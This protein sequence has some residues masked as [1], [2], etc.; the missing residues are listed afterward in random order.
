MP[1]VELTAP[2]LRPGSLRAVAFSGREAVSELYAYD[3]L[4][5]SPWVGLALPQNLELELLGS[6]AHLSFQT[7]SGA[8]RVVH[9]PRTE[10]VRGPETRELQASQSL[11]VGQ[12]RS[13]EVKGF[14]STQVGT[15]AAPSEALTSVEGRHT[16][17]ATQAIRI[18]SEREII[19]ECGDSRVV[20]GPEEVRIETKRLVMSAKESARLEADGPLLELTDQVELDAKAVKLYSEG[21][22]LELAQ[23][24]DVNGAQVNLNCGGGAAALAQAAAGAKLKPLQLKLHDDDMKP[25][26]DKKY[27]LFVGDLKLEGTT[28]GEG[29][30]DEQVPAEAKVAQLEL[31]LEDYPTGPA[32]HWPIELPDEPLPPAAGATGTVQRLRNLGYY[33]GDLVAE[34]T[35]QAEAALRA[36]QGDNQLEPTGKLD[37]RTAAKLEEI[38]GA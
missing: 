13:V 37:A 21:A 11:R 27:R 14:L 4:L 31:W 34:L 6:P 32:L 19:L 3:V 18:T 35:P 8:P 36:F 15:K 16:T 28:D 26:A 33:Q 38:H 24:A 25:F 23:N 12:G 29:G 7:M 17:Y 20:I 22:S 10:T 2:S 30:L 5:T 1:T 9:G